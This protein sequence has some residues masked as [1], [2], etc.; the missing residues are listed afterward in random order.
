MKQKIMNVKMGTNIP[1][2]GP[3]EELG[4]VKVNGVAIYDYNRTLINQFILEK[5]DQ[6][7]FD[8]DGNLIFPDPMRINNALI[9]GRLNRNQNV[10]TIQ[11]G[12]PTVLSL[13]IT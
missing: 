11:A 8:A 3:K 13:I 9:V 1:L 7:Y 6:G 4:D 5:E 12:R 2:L 10:V